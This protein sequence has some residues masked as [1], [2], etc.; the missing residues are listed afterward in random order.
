MKIKIIL[1]LAIL[2]LAA[3]TQVQSQGTWLDDWIEFH[4][5]PVKSLARYHSSAICKTNWIPDPDF[6]T[7]YDMCIVAGFHDPSVF[8]LVI[9]E[10][11]DDS[12]Y[13]YRWLIQW[14]KSG[15]TAWHLEWH[16]DKD[17]LATNPI[18]LIKQVSGD[19]AHVVYLGT[20]ETFPK[21][22]DA[23]RIAKIGT[24]ERILLTLPQPPPSPASGLSRISD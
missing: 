15:L 21:G 10:S 20:F 24:N 16:F 2:T 17:Y 13:I 23:I 14:Y 5:I 22:F 1:M 18:Q 4:E 6:N 19:P 8:W 12:T 11:D 9:S 3:A 7:A